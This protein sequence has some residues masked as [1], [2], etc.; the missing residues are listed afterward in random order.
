MSQNQTQKSPITLKGTAEELSGLFT[1]L[2]GVVSGAT[3][4][5]YG[6]YLVGK[7]GFNQ[8]LGMKKSG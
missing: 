2:A 8:V 4:D 6:S 1:S 7:A 5:L 3:G